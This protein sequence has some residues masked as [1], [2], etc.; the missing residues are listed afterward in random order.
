MEVNSNHS[1]EILADISCFIINIIFTLV[2][3][4]ILFDLCAAISNGTI[5]LKT[6]INVNYKELMV[7]VIAYMVLIFIIEDC[8]RTYGWCRE[9]TVGIAYNIIRY[10]PFAFMLFLIVPIFTNKMY[11]YYL[12]CTFFLV[13]L[14]FRY[15]RKRVYARNCSLMKQDEI[16]MTTLSTKNLKPDEL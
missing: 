4:F 10:F 16:D 5:D 3:F 6:V 9:S 14:L 2:K 13:D 15:I 12:Y 8:M 1:T 7:T 11:D